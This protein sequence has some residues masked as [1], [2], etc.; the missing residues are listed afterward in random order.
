MRYIIYYNN[1]KSHNYASNRNDLL[2]WLKLLKNEKITDIRKIY[3]SG[4]TD[5]VMDKYT[6]YIQR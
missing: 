2:E 6:R 3:R 5:S 4:V 1:N